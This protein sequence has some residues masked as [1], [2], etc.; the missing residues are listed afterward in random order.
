MAKKRKK[1]PKEAFKVPEFDEAEFMEREIEVS[2][3]GIITVLYAIPIAIVSFGLTIIGLAGI[4]FIIGFFSIFTLRYLYQ[5]LGIN[6]KDFEKKTWVGNGALMFFSWLLIWVLLLNPPFS[7]VSEPSIRNVE[8]WVQDTGGNWSRT[9]LQASGGNYQSADSLPAGTVVKLKVNA[10]DN[11]E[12]SSVRI[13]AKLN[14]GLINQ[15]AM[16]RNFTYDYNYEY[17][18]TLSQATSFYTFTISVA[19]TSANENR[20]EVTVPTS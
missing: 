15:T 12:V 4:G 14:Q 13:T 19:D 16:S 11:V 6:L 5:K 10:T 1:E 3:T 2:K 7:D 9:I 8:L 20:I 18:C 17:D